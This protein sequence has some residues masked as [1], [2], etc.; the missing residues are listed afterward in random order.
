[1]RKDYLVG[2]F[3]YQDAAAFSQVG[4]VATLLRNETIDNIFSCIENHANELPRVASSNIPE[5]S[6]ILEVDNVLSALIETGE[7]FP[8]FVEIGRVLC[9]ADK[10][11]A[12]RK[13]GE[14]HYKLTAF[15]GLATRTYPL[16]ATELGKQ[17]FEKDP[18]DRKDILAKL[19][20]RIPIIQQL[21]IMAKDEYVDVDSFF[22]K[23]L[24]HSTVNRRTSS[25]RTLIDELIRYKSVVVRERADKLIW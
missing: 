8:G 21:L 19:I 16:S 7:K 13:Y 12:Q 1:V 6:R 3:V 18:E 23:F 14:N 15:L 2:V 4:D 9:R 17:Y 11:P 5:F 25:T 20:L 24:S 10:E 22:A